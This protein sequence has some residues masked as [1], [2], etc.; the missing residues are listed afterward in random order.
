VTQVTK[1]NASVKNWLFCACA[2]ANNAVYLIYT[3]T[4]KHKKEYIMNNLKT[5]NA[6]QIAELKIL[7]EAY[8]LECAEFEKHQ[9]REDLLTSLDVFLG[10]S[11][12]A[13]NALIA[14][15]QELGLSMTTD[16][17]DAIEAM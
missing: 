17:V 7:I 16:T 10:Y 14:K 8:R 2:T 13:T 6:N 1:R 3:K 12:E 15:M 9:Q 11:E 5:L 4:A